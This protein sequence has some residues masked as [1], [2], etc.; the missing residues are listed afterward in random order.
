MLFHY[1]NC[2]KEIYALE[3]R[4]LDLMN[5]IQELKA[6]YDYQVGI[7]EKDVKA[8][9]A[10]ISYLKGQVADHKNEIAILEADLIKVQDM[11]TLVDISRDAYISDVEELKKQNAILTSELGARKCVADSCEQ[12]IKLLKKEV[13]E[14][15][16]YHGVKEKSHPSAH[17]PGAEWVQTE[18]GLE[19]RKK[20][21]KKR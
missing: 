21:S 5:Q 20:K 14:C 6:L 9:E 16:M 18:D 19:L 1:G 13:L 15:G 2:K 11:Y 17:M 3:G 10:D 8:Y 7:L 4:N 12:E